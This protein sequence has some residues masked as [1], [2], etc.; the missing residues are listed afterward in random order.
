MN[1]PRPE[2][3]EFCFLAGE[4]ERRDSSLNLLQKYR[5]LHR[6]RLLVLVPLGKSRSRTCVRL[7]LSQEVYYAGAS[8]RMTRFSVYLK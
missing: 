5:L 6:E 2:R 8:F 7:P 4:G 3:I 1:R